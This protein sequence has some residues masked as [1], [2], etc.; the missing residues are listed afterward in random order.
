MA[1]KLVASVPDISQLSISS[2]KSKKTK[3]K[4]V[5]V[6]DSWEDEDVDSDG[7]EGGVRLDEE[8]V[9]GADDDKKLETK[10]QD[11]SFLQDQS[12]FY[13][14]PRDTSRAR[15]SAP[16]KRP[17]KSVAVA[18]RLIA[19]AL[20]LRI[21]QTDEQRKFHKSQLENEKRRLEQERQKKAEE[22]KQKK[23]VWDD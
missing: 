7:D 18:N 4:V 8:V 15:G 21:K 19:G 14:Q 13:N 23:S 5:E 17:E 12:P 1:P 10:T 2:E 9:K 22:E 16:E 6:V 20:G 3:K 11:T